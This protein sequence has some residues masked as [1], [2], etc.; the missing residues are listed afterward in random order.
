MELLK[1]LGPATIDSE[2]CNMA[3]DAGG[4]VEWL[5]YFMEFLLDQLKTNMN[6]ELVQ[7]YI[8]LFLKVNFVQVLIDCDCMPLSTTHSTITHAYTH[9]HHSCTHTY[10]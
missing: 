1:G 7:S 9:T 3:P 6:Y 10:M 4:S 8:G 2:F 5:E